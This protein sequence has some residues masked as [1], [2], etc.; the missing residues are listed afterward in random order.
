VPPLKRHIAAF[1]EQTEVLATMDLG[2]MWDRMLGEFLAEWERLNRQG[3]DGAAMDRAL[4]S[5]MDDLSAKP[6]EDLARQS[7]SVA[8]NQGRA[9]SI[10]Q[11][12]D[13]GEVEYVVR[14]E[15]LD[16]NTCAACANL[17]GM[18]VRVDE[19]DFEEY[20]PPSKCL[21]GDRCRGFYVAVSGRGEA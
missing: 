13:S 8:Y 7:S 16:S 1:A 18:V 21:G 6:L 12:G 19:P 10:L 9:V 3:I 14:S 4:R 5:F 17:D 11:A 2:T 20:M 15:L